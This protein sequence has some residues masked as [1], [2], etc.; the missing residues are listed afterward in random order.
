MTLAWQ[1]AAQPAGDSTPS[2]P[3]GSAQPAP[4]Q[5]APSQPAP[6]AVE[7]EPKADSGPAAP[8][9]PDAVAGNSPSGA[10]DTS[11]AAAVNAATSTGE[12]TE[13]AAPTAAPTPDVVRPLPQ[14]EAYPVAPPPNAAVTPETASAAAPADTPAVE[15]FSGELGA[16]QR[17]MFLWLGVRNDLVRDS[18]FDQFAVND[19]LPAFSLGAGAVVWT[20]HRLS[21][22]AFALWEVA[23][24]NSE[25]RGDRTELTI[26]RLGVGP[27]LR[28]HLHYRVYAFGRLGVGAARNKATRR[29]SL[30][31]GELVSKSW[32]FSSALSAGAA[33][34]VLGSPAGE[35]RKPRAWLVADAGYAL[36]SS[37]SLDYE[38]DP[39]S[40]GIPERT[41]TYHA[42]ELSLNAPMFRLAFAGSY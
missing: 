23:S 19:S 21:L 10:S 36:T 13:V 5:P 4:A 3:P 33:V 9:Q 8:S 7:R 16:H 1:A 40:S 34:E 18:N 39:D 2:L 14:R 38:P 12:D 42:G 15:S 30:F 37:A 31:D 35:L 17:H 32:V 26:Q 29:S 25:V 11:T 27:E 6:S 20:S 28:Y 24:R 22:A 41:E